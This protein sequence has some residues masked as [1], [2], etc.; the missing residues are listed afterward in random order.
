M[1][2]LAEAHHQIWINIPYVG[3]QW[4]GWFYGSHL[5]AQG[6]LESLIASA[7]SGAGLQWEVLTADGQPLPSI[8]GQLGIPG[9]P[10]LPG[11][12]F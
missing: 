4:A 1:N 10:P 5:A 3:R 8:A 7:A 9:L 2:P 6:L 12:N 11:L